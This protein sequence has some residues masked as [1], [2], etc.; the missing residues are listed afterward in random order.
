MLEAVT[1]LIQ[2]HPLAVLIVL[3]VLVLYVLNQHYNL[4][5]SACTKLGQPAAV[6]PVVDP[7]KTL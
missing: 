5:G 7:T 3:V 1:K 4:V 6:A 2:D